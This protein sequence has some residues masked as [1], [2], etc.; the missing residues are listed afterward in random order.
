MRNLLATL[1]VLN[2]SV[3]RRTQLIKRCEKYEKVGVFVGTNYVKG[4]RAEH[5]MKDYQKNPEPVVDTI[6]I[7]DLDDTARL[8]VNDYNACVLNS[9]NML[10]AD[11]DFGDC[12]LSKF[13]GVK[14]C[15][16]V[17]AALH[18]LKTLDEDI[19]DP[20]YAFARESYRVYRTHSGARVICTS[21]TCPWEEV[22]YW[23]G[24]L[25]RFIRTD[26]QYMALCQEQRCYRARLT[27]KPWRHNGDGCYHVCNLAHQI[28]PD[29]VAPE[30]R[31]QLQVHDDLTLCT[32]KMWEESYL[33]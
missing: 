14:D 22:G 10:V 32:P 21:R 13:A 6:G 8:T 18:H 29:V 19:H 11:V 9:K 15:G 26:P 17:V 24:R 33:A 5:E 27:P 1:L 2:L 4:F 25:M 3:S 28:G 31:D 20:P 16:E 23:A 7:Y 12:R 30:L